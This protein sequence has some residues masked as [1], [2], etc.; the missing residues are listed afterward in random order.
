[1]PAR[2]NKPSSAYIWGYTGAADHLGIDRK[3]FW[4]MRNSN[5]LTGRE[6]K[7]LTPRIIGGQPAFK[8]TTLDEFMSPELNAPGAKAHD[9]FPHTIS[10]KKL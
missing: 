7:M 3:T 10:I 5:T 4:R 8:K 9:P 6:K 1:M 2:K